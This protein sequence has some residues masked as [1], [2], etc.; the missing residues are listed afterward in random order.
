MRFWLAS[1]QEIFMKLF[2]ESPSNR[3]GVSVW[4]ATLLTVL[5][6]YLAIRAA[7]PIADLLGVVIGFVAILQPDNTVS[8]AQ[9][10]KAIADLRTAVVSKSPGRIGAV[11]ADAE[12][13]VA[14]VTA[15]KSKG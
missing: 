2:F 15:D 8:M 6:Q 9:L 5:A 11:I 14:G 4:L 12:G 3:A 7:P 13:I 1:D 10:E